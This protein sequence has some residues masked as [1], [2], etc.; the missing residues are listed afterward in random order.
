MSDPGV[1]VTIDHAHLVDDCDACALRL[2]DILRTHEGVISIGDDVAARVAVTFDPAVCSQDCITTTLNHEGDA[3]RKRFQHE[4]I[5]V[6]GMDCAG[7]AAT[8]ERAVQRIDG[9]SSCSINFQD[10]RLRLEIDRSRPGAGDLVRRRIRSLG[11][12]VEQPADQAETSQGFDRHKSQL[13]L[14]GAIVCMIAAIGVHL[15]GGAT[16]LERA[17]Y[18]MTI[19]VGGASV[20]RAGVVGLFATRRPD[21]KFLMTVAVCGA[22][23]ID[24]WMEGALVVVLFGLGE[25]LEGIAVGR[26]RSALSSL[27]AGMPAT[28]LVRRVEE[29]IV[30]DVRVP[31]ADVQHGDIVVVRPGE[32]V[33]ADGRVHQGASS[34]N[35]SSITG[36]SIPVDKD[37]EDDVYAGSLNGEARLLI[38]VTSSPGDTTLDRIARAVAE[39]QANT[40]PSERWVDSFARIYTPI[41]MV[42]AMLVMVV[43]PL[44]AG[45]S[46]DEWIYRG[47]A[48]LILACPCA[49]VI[50][51][52][53]VIVS[54]LARAA[55]AGILI[56]GGEFL[57]RAA[58]VRAL[59][60]DKTGTVTAGNPQVMHV[61]PAHEYSS[62][63]VLAAA[64]ALERESEHPIATAIVEHA[65]EARV[66]VGL[67]EHVVAARGFGVRG[68]LDEVNVQVGSE[69][70]FAEHPEAVV[71]HALAQPLTQ[72]GHTIVV[73]ASERKALGVIGL[74]DTARESSREAVA[75]LRAMG[76]T[77]IEL[78]SGDHGAAVQTVGDAIG[79]D[80]VH[81]DLLPADKVSR[82]EEMER[83]FGPVVMVGDGVNDAPALARASLGIAMGTGGS[84]T[85]IEA[86]D[87]AIIGDNLQS[88]AATV[89][90]ARWSRRLVQQNIGFA[91]GTKIVAAVLALSGLLALWMAVL[92][93]VGA[94]L[95]VVTNGMRLLSSRPLTGDFRTFRL[96]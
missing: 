4:L 96:P 48:F 26:S 89:V 34:V 56:K 63:D 86:A 94:T 27:V 6:G 1:T 51:T 2:V 87:I 95:L 64:A 55:R 90:L 9:V 59:A 75:Q 88:V 33:P 20:A 78:L 50:S 40:S 8:I 7:C 76:M 38:T 31:V 32:H 24:A 47:L 70:Y 58:S 92:V 80:R 12:T 91:L 42:C 71:I 28:A 49:L 79:V 52:P 3:L 30:V 82:I 84:P 93:D 60:L 25:I 74:L 36:E 43:P 35:Q 72:A 53:V 10:A 11:F 66:E 83:E 29:G 81:G 54:A 23:A 39:A 65:R 69:R 16:L 15:A 18:A 13:V 62:A 17:L 14:A 19:V 68:V 85:A 57:E 41:V 73:V 37:V 45:A 46:W 77:S 44:A 22:V 5:G 61:V 67:A 21:M